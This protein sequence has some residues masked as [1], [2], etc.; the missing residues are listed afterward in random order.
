MKRLSLLLALVLALMTPFAI[1]EEVLEATHFESD[2][3]FSIDYDSNAWVILDKNT[4]NALTDIGL[5]MMGYDDATLAQYSEVVKNTDLVYLFNKN[6]M[7]AN[8]NIVRSLGVTGLTVDLL[9]M[10][11]SV[12]VSQYQE[13][14]PVVALNYSQ[15]GTFGENK[16]FEINMNVGIPDILDMVMTQYMTVNGDAMYV[17]TLASSPADYESVEAE[18]HQV[19][20]SFKMQ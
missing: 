9:P 10:L 3:G 12:F 7:G 11:E 16:F 19:L 18:A 6:S 17:I 5:N 1:A 4:T 2:L 15:F 14:Y 8:L 13:I 20:E